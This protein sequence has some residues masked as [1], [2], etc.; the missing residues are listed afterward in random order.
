[1]NVLVA[2]TVEECAAWTGTA[3]VVDVLRTSATV[4]VLLQDARR[5][6]LLCDGEQT[7]ARLK[8]DRADMVVLAEEPLTI[9]QDDNSPYVARKVP[10]GQPVLVVEKETA[11][12]FG[13]LSSAQLV[14]LGGFCNFT[15]I[16]GLV[17]KQQKDVLV[18][19]A[20]L[21]G[22]HLQEEDL[23]CAT[24]FKN[25]LQGTGTPQEALGEFGNTVRFAEFRSRGPRTAA[26]DLKIALEIDGL[27]VVVQ[28]HA[29]PEGKGIACFP[30]G[31]QTPVF[32]TP[33]PGLA[34]LELKTLGEETDGLPPIPPEDKPLPSAPEKKGGLKG[35][36]SKIVRSVKEEKA[37]VERSIRQTVLQ[38]RAGHTV[39]VDDPMDTLLKQSAR[40]PAEPEQGEPLPISDVGTNP[41]EKNPFGQRSISL[42][43]PDEPSAV[44]EKETGGVK[45]SRVEDGTI[46]HNE[47]GR[48]SFSLE[49][50]PLPSGKSNGK[51]AIVLFSG[52]LDSTTC[53]YWALD[54]GYTCEALTVSYGQRHV[55]EVE[56]AQEITRRL[57]VTHHLIELHLPW[58]AADCSLV[59]KEQPLPDIA[60]E[61][62]PSAGIPSTY[63]PGRN[64]MFMSIAGSLLDAVRAQ[65][66]IAGPNA[67]DFS[68]YPDCTPAF[69]K[70]AGEALNR[71]TKQGVREGIEVLAPL[72]RLSKAE[73]VKLA[74]KLKVPFELTWSC[75]AGGDKPC[76]HCDSCKLRAKGFEEAGVHDTALD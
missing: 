53:L 71:G 11:A 46:E 36:F 58:L 75:Y 50:Q 24:G 7:V 4:G 63:V 40:V 5:R 44:P 33:E 3:I 56:S 30:Y 28:L 8:A 19:P 16:T 52:G 51:K 76:G 65:A 47:F 49:T 13:A 73:I 39:R 42:E 17:T 38:R 69:F 15:A 25:V 35:I 31:T 22:Q 12:A 41:V 9:R 6:V 43:S 72:M 74:A 1:M 68:G 2:R 61:Q 18:V 55:R 59:N 14:L 29:L 23:L 57:G 34:T 48:P 62:I 20:S 21:F 66:I 26:Q 45:I 32:H 27:P 54:R 60:V 70:A 37:E 10:A 64:L 67:I